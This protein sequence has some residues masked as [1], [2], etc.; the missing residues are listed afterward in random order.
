MANIYLNAVINCIELKGVTKG[1]AIALANRVNAATG[2]CFPSINTI[3]SDIGYSVSAVKRSLRELKDRA[4]ITATKQTRDDNSQ[5]SNLYWLAIEK[6]KEGSR[7]VKKL[8]KSTL[9]ATR[10]TVL[11]AVKMGQEFCSDKIETPKS[12]SSQ[13]GVDALRELPV[14]EREIIINRL[15]GKP[16]ETLQKL[17]SKFGWEHNYVQQAIFNEVID[18]KREQQKSSASFRKNQT[19]E[20]KLSDRSWAK[21][22]ASENDFSPPS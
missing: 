18:F 10:A 9:N 17:M 4:Y 3:A 11:R 12:A 16:N 14:H 13:K 21:G 1:V 19:T 15:K 6:F 7:P 5:C 20:E 22:L 2:T 8:A